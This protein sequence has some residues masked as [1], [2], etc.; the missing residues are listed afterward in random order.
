[1]SKL[2]HKHHYFRIASFQ[3][4]GGG[5]LCSRKRRGPGNKANFRTFANFQSFEVS[6]VLGRL[7]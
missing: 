7:C 3:T 5:S 2:V 4:H 1:M 6:F